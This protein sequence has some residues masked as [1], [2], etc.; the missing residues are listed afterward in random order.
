[1]ELVLPL[2]DA[3]MIVKWNFYM[4][5]SQENSRYD[6]IIGQDLLL[7]LKLDFCFSDHTIRVDGG[8]YKG[9]TISMK[10]PFDLHDDAIFRNEELWESEDVLDSTRRM[11]RILDAQYQKSDLRKIMSNSKHLNND[12]RIVLYDVLTKY[13]F[14]FDGTLGTWKTKPVDLEL[15]S[16]A[17]PYHAKP[18]PVPRAHEAV[19]IS[20][21]NICA[22]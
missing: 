10:D 14:I 4:G 21:Y 6:M 11:R 17:K 2:L 9:C 19:S 15:Q 16:V 20:K 13:E 22:S 8:A 3:T 7:E 5:D 1:M 18:Y 12:E